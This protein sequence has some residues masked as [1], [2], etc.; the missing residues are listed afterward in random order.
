MVRYLKH[1]AH[2][3]YACQ[4]TVF[5]SCSKAGPAPSGDDPPDIKDGGR[6]AV[7]LLGS[8]VLDSTGRSMLRSGSRCRRQS[9]TTRHKGVGGMAEANLCRLDVG[10]LR[11]R[12]AGIFNLRMTLQQHFF[13]KTKIWQMLKLVLKPDLVQPQSNV[14]RL[15]PKG[16][17]HAAISTDCPVVSLTLMPLEQLL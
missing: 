8:I 13:I 6:E 11:S 16:L 9:R 12:L 2:R 10:V 17:T 14:F 1:K 15:G 7:P 5:L 4:L 3:Q